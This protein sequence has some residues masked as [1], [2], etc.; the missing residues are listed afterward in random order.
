MANPNY[1][2]HHFLITFV[3]IQNGPKISIKEDKKDRPKNSNLPSPD[4]R[5]PKINIII[6]HSIFNIQIPVF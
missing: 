1:Q 6:G 5:T 3:K 2:S 4:K